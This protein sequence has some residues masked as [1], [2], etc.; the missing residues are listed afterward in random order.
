MVQGPSIV[1]GT[2]HIAL[3]DLYADGHHRMYLELLTQHWLQNDY[4]GTLFVW[5]S[6][7][8][9]RVHADFWS[10]LE[11]TPVATHVL[12]DVP[13]DLEQGSGA[14]HLLY[15]DRWHLHALQAAHA[16]GADHVVFMYMDHAQLA[17]KRFKGSGTRIS[18]ILFKPPAET[19]PRGLK[20]NLKHIRKQVVLNRMAAA[21]SIASVFVLDP[22]RPWEAP[23]VY[24]P[25]GIT[26]PEPDIS[27]GAIRAMT[28]MDDGRLFLMFGD[29]SQRKGIQHLANAWNGQG[30][31]LLAGRVPDHEPESGLAVGRL[32]SRDDVTYMDGY[33]S[34]ERMA[35]LF[36]ACDVVLVPYDGHVGSSNVLI[37]AAMAGKPVIACADGLVGEWVR[38]FGLG[39]TVDPADTD[40]LRA[41][42]GAPE[43]P[44]NP[45]AAAEFSEGHSPERMGRVFFSTIL[46]AHP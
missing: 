36:Q 21:P 34:N 25:D 1:S 26:F 3:I 41:A 18:G 27:A 10:A 32:A 37:R 20:A 8:F 46:K 40:A 7:R 33:V 44:F 9:S 42:I 39:T 22:T 30:H 24:L 16:G 2:P 38:S 5:V 19:R 43:V 4:P 12:P 17:S 6:E 35:A 23:Y 15:C 13:S 29:L 28:G 11:A 14:R 45:E 31:L